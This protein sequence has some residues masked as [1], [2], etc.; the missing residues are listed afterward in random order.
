MDGLKV[1]L[2]AGAEARL[3]GRVDLHSLLWVRDASR[4]EQ[5]AALNALGCGVWKVAE[6]SSVAA[7]TLRATAQHRGLDLEV[8]LSRT[9]RTFTMELRVSGDG[10]GRYRGG[11]ISGDG[12]GLVR[13]SKPRPVSDRMLGEM[14]RVLES[15]LRIGALVEALG[16]VEAG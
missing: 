5:A 9:L 10:F 7:G 11:G 4:E 13:V 16:M 14:V 2:P 12:Q 8:R 15:E 1:R 6:R 3:E